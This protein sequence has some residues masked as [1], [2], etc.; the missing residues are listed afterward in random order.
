MKDGLVNWTKFSQIARCAAIV[1]DCP[2]HAPE[3][4]IVRS[5]E[6][7]LSE[8]PAYSLE[9]DELYDL[10]YTYRR[11]GGQTSTSSRTQSNTVKRVQRKS[12]SIFFFESMILKKCRCFAGF[13]A[14]HATTNSIMPQ[15]APAPFHTPA[16]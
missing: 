10:S 13:L 5:I 7:L 1:L 16:S 9:D 2:R 6:A 15:T 11:R 4:P 14:N 8:C 12:N 3:L